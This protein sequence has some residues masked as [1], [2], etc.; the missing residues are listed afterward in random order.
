MKS[1]SKFNLT[2]FD[3]LESHQKRLRLLSKTAEVGDWHYIL[4]TD[5]TIWSEY[6][7]DFYELDKA[8][9]CSTLL[10][11]TSLYSGLEKER[12][13]GFIDHAIAA[14]TECTEEFMIAM[15]D[16]RHKWQATTIYPMLDDNEELIGLYGILQN[17]TLKKEAEE[18]KKKEHLFYNYP[19]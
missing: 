4:K 2:T 5:T 12:M 14:K 13:L 19:R 16:G 9:D 15:K 11:K 6:I 18:D 1:D 7:Y 3:S 17:I 8:F 10:E